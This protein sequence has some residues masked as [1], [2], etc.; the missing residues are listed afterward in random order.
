VFEASNGRKALELLEREPGIGAV[1]TDL[2]M[3]EIGGRELAR[4]IREQWSN[5]PVVFMTG[6]TDDIVS[7]RGLLDDGVP[8]LK[9]P[10]SPDTITQKMQEVMGAISEDVASR[11][12]GLSVDA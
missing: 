4:R 11:N 8:F 7:R 1:L 10:L 9:K 2:A 3:P 5:L 6:Y 12:Q